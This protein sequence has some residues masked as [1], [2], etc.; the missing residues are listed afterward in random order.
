[1]EN[2]QYF[3]AHQSNQA[4]LSPKQNDYATGPWLETLFH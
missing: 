1:M 2:D 4:I 3:T